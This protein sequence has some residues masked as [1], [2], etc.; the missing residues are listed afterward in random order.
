MGKVVNQAMVSSGNSNRWTQGNR[1][2][3]LNTAWGN[4]FGKKAIYFASLPLIAAMVLSGCMAKTPPKIDPDLRSFTDKEIGF[5]IVFPEGWDISLEK[6][7]L[8]TATYTQRNIPLVTLTAI[9]E[10][11]IPILRHY[12]RITSLEKFPRRLFKYA[13]GNLSK[14]KALSP[15]KTQFG[16]ASLDEIVW[17]AERDGVPIIVHS[18]N[19]PLEVALVQLHFEF[20]SQLYQNPDQVIDSVLDG[21]VILPTVKPSPERLAATYRTI[22]EIY[23]S[24][25]LWGEAGNAFREAVNAQPDNP[26]LYVL[27]GESDFKVQAFDRA[28]VAY[29]RAVDLSIENAEAYKGL[30]ET[31]LKLGAFDDAITA[32]K[33]GLILSED[34]APYYLLLGNAYLGKGDTKEAIRNFQKLLRKERLET[35]GHLGIGKAYLASELYEQAIFEFKEVLRSRPADTETHCLLE[36]VYTQLN[37]TED[38]AKEAALCQKDISSP[39]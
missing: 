9:A 18:I 7:R 11:E 23:K 8:F 24:K 26:E 4:A 28:L 27:L 5:S 35:D 34:E 3:R 29:K 38:A 15:K 6:G 33:R 39:S 2:R 19:L 12:L 30:G 20:P 13:Q 16:G 17:A 1:V 14:I 37:A 25:S 32:T 36:K 22:G 21:I 31:H 10:T